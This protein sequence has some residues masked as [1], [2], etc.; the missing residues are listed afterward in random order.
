MQI[1]RQ[2]DEVISVPVPRREAAP[3]PQETPRETPAP[4][5]EPVP[6]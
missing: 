1:G 2:I 3:A 5:E 4:Q 6:A